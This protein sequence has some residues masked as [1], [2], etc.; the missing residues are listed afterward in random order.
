MFHGCPEK[1]RTTNM[2]GAVFR[3][4][5]AKAR[6][7]FG[8]AVARVANFPAK[9]CCPAKSGGNGKSKKEQEGG[10]KAAE[11]TAERRNENPPRG[12]RTFARHAL[13]GLVPPREIPVR[14]TKAQRG[15][16]VDESPRLRAAKHYDLKHIESNQIYLSPPHMRKSRPKL[17]EGSL[18][19]IIIIIHNVDSFR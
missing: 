15:L 5:P 13:H 14:N 10:R 18:D 1:I 19:C 3:G 11:E 4:T 12:H 7:F 2:R 9:N 6:K 17:S 16:H 8:E